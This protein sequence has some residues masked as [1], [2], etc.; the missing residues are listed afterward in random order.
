[1]RRSPTTK[2][3]VRVRPR[4]MMRCRAAVFN[5]RAHIAQDSFLVEEKLLSVD[6]E[7][8]TAYQANSE[9]R[10]RNLELTEFRCR[11]CCSALQQ[12][13]PMRKPGFGLFGGGRRRR[14]QGDAVK[15]GASVL[16][17]I[18]VWARPS[19]VSL[20]QSAILTKHLPIE[21]RYEDVDSP[22]VA[23]FKNGHERN[24][25][26]TFFSFSLGI[27]LDLGRA[28]GVKPHLFMPEDL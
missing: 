26:I 22:E 8:S 7:P 20:L 15:R 13:R 27:P 5:N 18:V 28:P 4:T 14:T 23:L 24:V 10:T 21:F 16:S 3:R 11:R 25:C 9:P 6:D 1:M 12:Q 17:C 2:V 19:F